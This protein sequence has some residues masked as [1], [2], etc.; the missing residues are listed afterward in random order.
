MKLYT[1]T[2]ISQRPDI[3]LEKESIFEELNS[4]CNFLY[5][6]I[7]YISTYFIEKG[8]IDIPGSIRHFW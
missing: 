7:S 5:L 2:P 3:S 6:H 1:T 8:A 4:E